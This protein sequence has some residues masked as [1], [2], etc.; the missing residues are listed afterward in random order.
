MLFRSTVTALTGNDVITLDPATLREETILQS[1]PE[2]SFRWSPN[3]DFLIYYPREEGVKED[4]PLRRIVS[5]ADRIPNSRGR[6]FLAKYNLADGISERLTYG[7]HST[8]LQDISPDGKYMLYS[9]SKENITQR[10]FSLSSLYQVDLETLKVDTLFYEDRFVGG[11]GYSPD[12]KQLL[13][14]GSPEA[15][16]GIGKNCGNQIG[17]ASCRE[18]V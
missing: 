10:P 5:P 8:Y 18:R 15:F 7:N 16:G 6:S 4:G 9:T 14:T 12:G 1:I 17:R 11:A 3:E 2:Q 13:L